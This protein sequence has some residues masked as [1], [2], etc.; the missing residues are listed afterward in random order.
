[1]APGE[2]TSIDELT[3]ERVTVT[4][5][6]DVV[7]ITLTD[8]RRRNPLSRAT[9]GDLHAAFVGAAGAHAVVLASTGP[10]W[11]TGH[12]L[13]EMSEMDEVQLRDLFDACSAMMRAIENAPQPFV[14]KVSGLATAAGCQLAATCD[15]VVA[16]ADARFCTPGGKGGLFCHT[17]MVAVARAI[18]RRRAAE[19]AM[20]GDEVDAATAADWGLVNRVVPADELDRATADMVRRLTRGSRHAKAVGKQTLYRQMDER[21]DDAYRL[22][23][24]MMVAGAATGDG[25][26]GTRAFA[27]KR[28]PEFSHDH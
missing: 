8:E 7:T 6:D 4:R 17:P 23:G 12:D 21:I 11:S 24:E 10:V 1:M 27:E 9:I 19:M 3:T 26:E 18:G 14:A 20:T 22:A 13:R 5:S 16:S 25:R 15:V 2:T 28:T